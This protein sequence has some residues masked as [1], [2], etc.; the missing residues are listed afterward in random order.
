MLQGGYEV[1][2]ER[3]VYL[4]L[5]KGEAVVIFPRCRKARILALGLL[6]VPDI[7]SNPLV[8]STARYIAP[9]DLTRL[10]C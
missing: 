8:R 3:S 5:E 1:D 7:C 6:R 10:R 4:A 2:P 9:S